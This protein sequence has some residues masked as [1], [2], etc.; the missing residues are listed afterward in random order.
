MSVFRSMKRA[1]GPFG[2][3]R[4]SRCVKLLP[5][6]SLHG[7]PEHE[8]RQYRPPGAFEAPHPSPAQ[9]QFPDTASDGLLPALPA[10]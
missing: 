9:R 6:L 5:P 4:K 2:E 10:A 3:G 1:T 8:F 7:P